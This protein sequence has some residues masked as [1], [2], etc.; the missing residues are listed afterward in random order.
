MKGWI[1]FARLY[2]YW[3]KGAGKTK[4]MTQLKIF[5]LSNHKSDWKDSDQGII[6]FHKLKCP[7]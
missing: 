7:Y 5:L 1:A 3:L 2:Y 4:A 6:M